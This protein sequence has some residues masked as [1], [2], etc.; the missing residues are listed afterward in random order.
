MK[1][2][3]EQKTEVESIGEAIKLRM[4]QLKI[5]QIELSNKT[6]ISQTYLSQ[7]INDKRE[8]SI[9]LIISIF[10]ALGMIIQ[11]KYIDKNE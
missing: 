3:I 1:T 9:K 8:P 5:T 2:I 11:I 4:K 10:N 6:N 7:I